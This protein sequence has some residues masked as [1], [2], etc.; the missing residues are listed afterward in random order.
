MQTAKLKLIPGIWAT[1]W[2]NQQNDSAPGE[3]SD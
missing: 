3:N 1:S 2:Q